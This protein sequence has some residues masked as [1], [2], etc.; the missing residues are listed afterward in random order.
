MPLFV[1]GATS[2]NKEGVESLINLINSGRFDF[3]KWKQAKYFGLPDSK[4]LARERRR[5]TEV[6]DAGCSTWSL[7]RHSYTPYDYLWQTGKMTAE[8]ALE[9]VK[10]AEYIPLLSDLKT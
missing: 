5:R 2:K 1:K 3:E 6:R 4:I 9:Y 7:I 8:D 10:S